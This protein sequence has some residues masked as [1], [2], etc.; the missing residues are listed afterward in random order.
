MISQIIQY[1]SA[2]MNL[3]FHKV[4][5]VTVHANEVILLVDG[6]GV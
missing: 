6:D 4:T 1:M 3:I 5:F 2:L